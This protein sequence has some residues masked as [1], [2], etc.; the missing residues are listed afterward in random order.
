MSD[1][2]LR[3]QRRFEGRAKKN[4]K[5]DMK[6]TRRLDGIRTSA[7]LP[8]AFPISFAGSLPNFRVLY[9][10]LHKSRQYVGQHGRMQSMVT[11]PMV[12]QLWKMD[13]RWRVSLLIRIEL[14][15]N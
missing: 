14:K 1:C 2:Q 7:R 11:L 15:G 4:M 5:N 9:L 12:I 8:V 6:R 10:K 13:A 3:L